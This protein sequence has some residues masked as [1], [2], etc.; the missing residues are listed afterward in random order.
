MEEQ[1]GPVRVGSERENKHSRLGIWSFILA[2]LA[3]LAIVVAFIVV[4]TVGAQFA[5]GAN[6]Q[7]LTQQD[8]QESFENSPGSGVAII[9]AG[10]GLLASPILYLLGAVLGIAGLIQGRRRRLFAVLGT[11]LNGLAFLAI[12]GLFV[13]LFVIGATVAPPA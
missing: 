7:G 12:V 5:N 3:T 13:L 11:V 8:V 9:A 4:F 6:P 10:I 2:I 1:G